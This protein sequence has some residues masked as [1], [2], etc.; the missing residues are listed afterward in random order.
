MNTIADVA[1]S[2][3]PKP[4]TPVYRRMIDHPAAWTVGDFRSP[5]DYTVDLASQMQADIDD[6]LSAARRSGL[7]LDTVERANFPLPSMQPLLTAIRH[8][9]RDGR[10]FVVVRGLPVDRW[11]KDEIGMLYW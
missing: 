8:E 10:G 11:S 9:L 6:A 4:A 3:H 2:D 1:G 5:R 7:T